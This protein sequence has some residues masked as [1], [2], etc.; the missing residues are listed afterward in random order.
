MHRRD[1][2]AICMC[3][4]GIRKIFDIQVY[5]KYD[6]NVYYTDIYYK[7]MLTNHTLFKRQKNIVFLK[8][9]YSARAYFFKFFIA[10]S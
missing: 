3:V 5:S 1:C 4:Y 2:T 9:E 7:S 6:H 10:Y 8:T